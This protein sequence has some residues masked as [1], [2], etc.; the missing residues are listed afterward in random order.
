MITSRKMRMTPKQKPRIR[1][2]L[3]DTLVAARESHKRERNLEL[4]RDASK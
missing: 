1:I 2:R 3:P 4:F